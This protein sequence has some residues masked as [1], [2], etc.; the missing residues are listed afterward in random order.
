VR[1][2]GARRA[3]RLPAAEENTVFPIRAAACTLVALLAQLSGTAASAAFAAD[4]ATGYPSRPVR[5]IVPYP[6]G[7]ITDILA[8]TIAQHLTAGWG[9]QVI[10]DNRAGASGNIGVDIAARANPDGYTIVFGNSA[11]HAIN[12]G[13]FAKIPFDPVK[14]FAA[15]TLVASV[16]NALLVNPSL[17]A[18][19]VQD[20]VA[21]A[22][23]KPGQLTFG[24]NS[25][26]SSNH[27]AGEL[28]KTM[29]GIDIV[30]VPY[31]SAVAAGVDL[32]G[33]R[34]TMMFDNL[35]TAVPHV[36]AGRLR[37][38]ATTGAKRAPA[39]PDAPTMIESGFPG[40]VLTP[41]W[42]VFAPARTPREIVAKLNRDI[43]AVL[44]LPAVRES[45]AAQG[46][47]IVAHSPEAFA[48]YLRTEITRWGKVVK[49]S[50][51]KAD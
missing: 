36:R 1:G 51:A 28:L 30:H 7:G 13:L 42:G 46:A 27:L 35:P 3:S 37:V 14:D 10:V 6:P 38:L 40:F 9:Q 33:N 18:K 49:D 26:G 23:A 11:T 41:W 39:L 20:I 43:V 19:S 12:P 22:K 32:M 4:A 2:S 50:G 47:D 31:K 25:T 21:M 45:F 29:A 48:A 5:F 17:P 16:T 34:I 8:R 15:V 44:G 24:S